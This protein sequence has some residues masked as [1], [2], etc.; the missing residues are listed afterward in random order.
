MDRNTA[1]SYT[2]FDD[3][4][5][6]AVVWSKIGV[7]LLY[8]SLDKGISSKSVKYYL[9]IDFNVLKQLKNKLHHK[10]STTH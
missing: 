3:K 8:G 9:H 1:L 4:F 5:R 6:R 7:S 2:K 10:S